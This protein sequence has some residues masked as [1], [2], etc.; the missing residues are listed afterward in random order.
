MGYF[1]VLFGRSTTSSLFYPRNVLYA[2]ISV[3]NSVL[4]KVEGDRGVRGFTFKRA[5]C[6]DV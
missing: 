6:I 4:L 2:V 5:V 1:L 3:T